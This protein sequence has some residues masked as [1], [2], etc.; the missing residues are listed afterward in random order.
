MHS[1]LVPPWAR[2]NSLSAKSS[3]T[4]RMPWWSSGNTQMN[5][6][7]TPRFRFGS[8]GHTDHYE[9]SLRE[10]R[11]S[12]NYRT[13]LDT[14]VDSIDKLLPCFFLVFRYSCARPTTCRAFAMGRFSSRQAISFRGTIRR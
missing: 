4:P 8:M 9:R 14:M 5:F 2:A 11:R 7:A 12:D 13:D 1:V 3:H 10:E 6:A